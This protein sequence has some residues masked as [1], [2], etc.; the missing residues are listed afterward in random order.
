MYSK[1]LSSTRLFPVD[2]YEKGQFSEV[3]YTH[4]YFQTKDHHDGASTLEIIIF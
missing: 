4:G 1:N 3:K 2:T